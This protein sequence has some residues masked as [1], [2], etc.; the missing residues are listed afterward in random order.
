M[1]ATP[2]LQ[3]PDTTTACPL[4]EASEPLTGTVPSDVRWAHLD[5]AEFIAEHSRPARQ[6]AGSRPVHISLF[7]PTMHCASCVGFLEK[8]PGKF[9]GLLEARVDLPRKQLRVVLDWDVASL[10]ALATHLESSGYPP[11]FESD[12]DLSERRE[13]RRIIARLAVAGFAFGNIMLLALSDYVDAESFKNTGFSEA[14]GWI[15]MALSLPVLLYSGSGYWKS[16]YNAL[17][18]KRL[19]IDVP[20]ALG[21]GAIFVRSVADVL[22]GSGMGYFDSLA[23]LVFFLLIGKWYQNRTHANLTHERKYESWFPVSVVRLTDAGEETVRIRHLRPGDRIRVH[24]GEILPADGILREGTGW[25]DRS[26]ITGESDP[27]AV[28]PG[29]TLDAGGRWTGAAGVLEV[30]RPVETSHLTKLWNADAFE[31]PEAGLTDPVNRI[32]GVFTPVILAVAVAAG[33][34]HIGLGT[35]L[36]WNA[37]TATLI[38]ACPCALALSIPFA[39]G[40]ALRWLGRSGAFLKNALVVE[41]MA[42]VDTM[43]FDKTGT[44]THAGSQTV[45]VEAADEDGALQLAASLARS[46]SHPLSR[47]IVA[48]ARERFGAAENWQIEVATFEEKPGLGIEAEVAGHGTVRLGSPVFAGNDSTPDAS[49]ATVVALSANGCLQGRFVF[50][51]PLR[52][53]VESELEAIRSKY[54]LHLLSGD[55]AREATRFE[56][57]F[58]IGQMHFAVNP[59][60]KMAFIERLQRKGRNVAMVGDGLNDAGALKQADLGVAVVEDL[61]AFSPASDLILHASA[62]QIIGPL[63]RFAAMSRRTVFLLFGISLV[64]NLVG[65]A[66][67]VQGILTPVVAAILMPIS[68]MTVVLVALLRTSWAWKA[69]GAAA[70]SFKN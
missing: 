29:G 40:S 31:K 66:F 60:E 67:A 43:V 24:N 26:F 61:Y 9:K 68:S 63:M 18:D 30:V 11:E 53:G 17:K 6:Y 52:P 12:R 62:L 34:V 54:D 35:G 19:N 3:V 41:R 69:S 55:S 48:R 22:T 70:H 42:A 15:S 44:L 59:T 37:F 4:T 25:V 56:P 1:S 36:A 8:L 13:M 32:S 21:M 49:G 5:A 28:R 47:A 7:L 2:G 39:Y 58:G 38:V 27:V 14:F 10:A 23:G 65:I 20:V 64:Y 57:M 51:K 46:S 45:E 50:K 16:A 33:A